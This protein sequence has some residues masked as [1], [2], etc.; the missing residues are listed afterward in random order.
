MKVLY[1][2][3]YVAGAVTLWCAFQYA[4]SASNPC[5]TFRDTSCDFTTVKWK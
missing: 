3:S 2:L 1:A 5:S 4:V